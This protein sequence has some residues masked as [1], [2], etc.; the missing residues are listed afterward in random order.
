MPQEFP[1]FRRYLAGERWAVSER[2]APR[3]VA[4]I[5]RRLSGIRLPAEEIAAIKG[6]R[7]T[8][9]GMLMWHDGTDMRAFSDADEKAQRVPDPA[10]ATATGGNSPGAVGVINITGVI[11]EH[12]RQVE[13]VSGPQGTSCERIALAL[14]QALADPNIG[15]IVL[16]I[17]SPGGSVFGVQALADEIYAARGKKRLVAQ[18]NSLMASA[19]YWIG[20]A[21][22]EIV[23]SPGSQIGSIGVVALHEDVSAQAEMMGVK[24]TFI[25]AGKRKVEGN[26]LEPLTADAQANIQADVD[27]YYRDFVRAV[28]RNR[29]VKVSDVVNGFGEAATLKDGQA[30]ASGLAD[31]VATFE[32]TVQRLMRGGGATKNNRRAAAGFD[33]AELEGHASQLAAPVNGALLTYRALGASVAGVRDDGVP[34]AFGED[35]TSAAEL[36]AATIRPGEYHTCR[37]AGLFRLGCA[38][39]G[40]VTAEPEA[41]NS[42]Q[43]SAGPSQEPD[44]DATGTDNPPPAPEPPAAP[45]CDADTDARERDAYRRRRHAFLMRRHRE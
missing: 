19:A 37:A 44:A 40:V 22:E 20:S 39:A 21:A 17:D 12:A 36:E 32:E 28:A 26:A 6:P 45:E 25:Y 23:A 3:F 5:E 9:N 30:V 2:D 31:R 11:A 18:A 35:W 42:P 16:R 14:R 27:A 1:H 8:P 13:G 38:P 33:P 4:V 24:Y 43:G 7:E 34:L 41:R 10:A 29:N 15:S